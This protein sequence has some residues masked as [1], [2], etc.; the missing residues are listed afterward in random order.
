MSRPVCG[1]VHSS[2]QLAL[3]L[4]YLRKLRRLLREERRGYELCGK[5][6][7]DRQGALCSPYA[8]TA[9]P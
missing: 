4:V 5:L 3:S 7:R 9:D 1:Q 6:Q 2:L 8:D